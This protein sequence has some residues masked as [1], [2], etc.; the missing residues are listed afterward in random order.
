MNRT[1]NGAALPAQ[2][3]AGAEDS[4]KWDVVE[5]L[6]CTVER[7]TWNCGTSRARPFQPRQCR[8]GHSASTP[9]HSAVEHPF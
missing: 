2:V 1:G 4:A 8:R 7:S 9:S 3:L 5:H 6:A